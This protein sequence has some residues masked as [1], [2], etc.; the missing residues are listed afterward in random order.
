M[1]NLRENLGETEDSDQVKN[2][3]DDRELQNDP[4]AAA[5]AALDKSSKEDTKETPGDGEGS[6]DTDAEGDLNAEDGSALQPGDVQVG[7]GDDGGSSDAYDGT[8]DEDSEAAIEQ[9]QFSEDELQETIKGI[10]ED[11]RRQA[12][13]EV[14]QSFI[15]QNIMYNKATGELG[16]YIDHPAIQKRDKDGVPMFFNPETQKQFTGENPRAQAREWVDT[17]NKELADVFDRSVKA[18]ERAIMEEK[19]PVIETLRFAPKYNKLDPIRRSMLDSIIEDYEVTDDNGDV[20][21]YSCDLNRALAQVERQI[22]VIQK[23]Y[24]GKAAQ[25]QEPSGP[26]VDMKAGASQTESNGKPEF[27]SLAEALAWTQEQK[28]KSG[29]K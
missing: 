28:L 19:Q 23:N 1:L 18:K 8:G 3:D 13:N 16:A 10:E 22:S 29:K 27:K 15:K 11:A 2:L 6:R 24:A 5:F 4:W 12:M 20:I 25:K 26:A 21:G 7:E 14:A 9:A 17:Y